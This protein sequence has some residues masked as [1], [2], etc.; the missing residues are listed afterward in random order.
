[1]RLAD[2]S[3]LSIV[4]MAEGE[5]GVT[6]A[7]K[8]VQKVSIPFLWEEKPGTPKKGWKRENVPETAGLPPLKLITS[9]P[10]G[11]EEEPGKPL[12][13]FAQSPPIGEE[14]EEPVA[15]VTRLTPPPQLASPYLPL[16]P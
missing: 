5:L 1:M 6:Q 10:S 14:P 16:P 8:Q 9:V 12:A 3:K 7:G 13:C 11:W 15:C 4:R 2:Q